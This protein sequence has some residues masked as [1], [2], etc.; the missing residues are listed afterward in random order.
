MPTKTKVKAKP[1]LTW[2]FNLMISVLV[3]VFIIGLILRLARAVLFPFFI[4]L[5]L[6]FL[7]APALDF[8][9]KHKIPRAV[10]VILI[11]LVA[12]LVVYLMGSL[13][14]TSGKAFADEIPQYSHKINTLA[15]NLRQKLH[16]TSLEWDPLEWL[17]KLDINKI[18]SFLV[19]ALGPFLSFLTNLLLVFLFLVFIMIGHG[20]LRKKIPSAYSPERS[21]QIMVIIEHIR[22][23][24]QRYLA[25][26]TAINVGIGLLTTIF[27]LVLGLDF[28]VVF[29]FLAFLLSY[30]PN[31][32]AVFASAFPAIMA[33]FQFESPLLGLLVLAVLYLM[34]QA[35]GLLEV[36]VLGQGLG[37]S[38]LLVFFSLVFWGWLWGIAGMIL[39][40]PILAVIKIICFNIPALKPVA[41]MMS[42]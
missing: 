18:A 27:L 11:L 7:L 32:G 1:E 13:F 6:A 28:A 20:N 24:V 40:V 10:A 41:T 17:T 8:L 23:Q 4:S 31:F 2:N 26:K 19:S 36:K 33:F 9:I 37:L 14:Y 38:P 42:S 25:I 22:R 3:V 35:M 15:E 34:H 29:G 39:A 16:I 12:F 30:I 21:K 5:F